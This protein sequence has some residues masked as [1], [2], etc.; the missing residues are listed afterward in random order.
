MEGEKDNPCEDGKEYTDVCWTLQGRG[1]RSGLW[2]RPTTPSPDSSQISLQ[3]A[4]FS[5]QALYL[6]SLGT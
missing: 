5:E 1:A 6:D 4:L 2:S 3:V